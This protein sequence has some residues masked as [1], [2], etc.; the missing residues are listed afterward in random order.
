MF[1][2]LQDPDF[3]IQAYGSGHATQIFKSVCNFAWV[4]LESVPGILRPQCGTLAG[5]SWADMFFL[6]AFSRVT[7][8]FDHLCDAADLGTSFCADGASSFFGLPFPKQ[9]LSNESI[10]YVDDLFKVAYAHPDQIVDK[11]TSLGKAACRAFYS[12]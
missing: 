7:K 5:T 4:T 3:F 1:Y 6:S 11:I 2:E 8:R 9:T 12:N 10:T